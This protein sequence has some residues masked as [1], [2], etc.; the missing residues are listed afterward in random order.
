MSVICVK[1]IFSLD[2][3]QTIF[4][5]FRPFRAMNWCGAFSTGD[6]LRSALRLPLTIISRALGAGTFS[7]RAAKLAMSGK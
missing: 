5:L 1:L 3:H 2:D 6:A 7:G 4:V